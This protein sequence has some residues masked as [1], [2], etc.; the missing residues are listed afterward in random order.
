MNFLSSIV[1]WDL[2][3]YLHGE[4]QN[5]IT[6]VKLPISATSKKR[7]LLLAVNFQLFELILGEFLY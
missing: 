6:T 4:M 2:L 7:S 5:K 1:F 3:F